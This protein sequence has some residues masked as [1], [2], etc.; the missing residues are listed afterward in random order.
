MK[1]DIIVIGAG[2]GGLNMA[3]FMNK[4]G[5][6]VMLVDKKDETIG[7]DC[8][9][10]GCVPSKALIHVA[11]QVK[12]GQDAQRFGVKQTGKVDLKKVMHYVKSKQDVIREHENA[13][14]FKKQGIDVVLGEARF[15]SPKS[16]TVNDKEYTAKRIIIATGSSPRQLNL[17]GIEKVDVQTNETI[18]D[19][20]KL[21]K[22]LVV[23]GGGPI[24]IELGQA[25]QNLG[26]QVTVIQR[27]PTFLP[28]ESEEVARV[29]QNQLEN[30]GMRF[31]FESE[32]VRFE[33]KNKV[34]IKNKRGKE[35][36]L[37]FDAVLASI[38]RQINL[39]LDLEKASIKVEDHKIVVNEYLQTTNKRVFAVGDAA[40]SMM[41]THAA[42][43]HAGIVLNNFFSPVKK[44]LSYDKFSWV[45]YTSPEIA[46]FGLQEKALQERK[47][48]YQKR[49]LDFKDDDRAIVDGA[50][51]AKLIV[52]VSKDKIV[53]GT[54]VAKNAGELFQELS[55]AMTANMKVKTLFNKVYPYPT[56]SRIN[57]RLISEYLSEKLTGRAKKILRWLY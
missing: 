27:G 54:M 29:L 18:F 15:A 5:F 31:C 48:P 4:A 36:T 20:E 33:G 41:F 19:L 47:I 21:P 42:E 44:K 46:T 39:N 9:N 40:G 16:I 52:Y 37:K 56:A 17:P 26:S 1:Y 13:S 38:G 14:Y 49:V 10:F 8:L 35:T 55:L 6:S 34:V 50:T 30:E 11:R 2:S 43:V 12:A 23:V 57:K 24:G 28:K 32:P 22:N 53:G 7:G 51:G 25:F 45:T 3:M